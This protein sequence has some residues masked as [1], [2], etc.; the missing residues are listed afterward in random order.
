MVF[1]SISFLVFFLVTATLYYCL[2]HRWRIRLLL[3]ASYSFYGFWKLEYVVLLAAATIVTYGCGLK[4]GTQSE[5]TK[6]KLFLVISIATNVCMLVGFKYLN[7]LNEALRDFLG[8]IDISY[9]VPALKILLPVG[10]SFYTFKT[11]S[12]VVDVYR[13]DQKPEKQLV[14]YALYVSFF[15]QLLAGPIERSGIL[16]TQFKRKIEFDYEKVTGGLRLVAWGL[17]KK[18]VIA[19][20]VAAMVN[21]VYNNPH[22]Y[23]GI[24]F[25]LATFFYGYQIY[26]D[27][28]GYSDIAIGTASI[29]GFDSMP[30]FRRP[31]FSGSLTEFWRRWHISLSTWFRDYLYIPLGGSRTRPLRWQAN[32]IVVFIVS[33][34]WHGSDWTFIAWGCVH[35]FYLLFGIWTRSW[36]AKSIELFRLNRFP[37]LH[38]FIAILITF[39]LVNFA[40]IFFRANNINDAIYIATHLFSGMGHFLASLTDLKYVF[41]ALAKLG[42]SDNEFILSFL[43]I[44]L[45]EISQFYAEVKG[46]QVIFRDQ[47]AWLRWFAYYAL[48]GIIVYFGSFNTVQDFV[49]MQF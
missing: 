11:I 23:E 13:G 36:R 34:L 3:V 42:V 16:L 5:P 15:P 49:Y 14:P 43:S 10:I 29:L 21:T 17:F 20:R 2:T 41:H 32:L 47:P 24:Q 46:T 27:F 38:R 22:E 26:C 28:S 33:G 9:H 19:D 6:K 8:L 35:V 31:Y 37:K 25:I 48:A 18:L 7:F 12:Y 39:A 4:M 44:G 45:L 40:W 1:N 30:N